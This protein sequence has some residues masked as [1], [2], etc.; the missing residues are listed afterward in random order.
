M[1]RL[2]A[3]LE[4]HNYPPMTSLV[5]DL[6]DGVKLIQIM[7][8]RFIFYIHPS[9]ILHIVFAYKRRLWVSYPYFKRRAGY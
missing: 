7:V 1:S 4:A 9:R 3:K 6:S 8:D 5:R 2:N